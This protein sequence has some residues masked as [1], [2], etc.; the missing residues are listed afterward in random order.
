MG[1]FGGMGGAA[2]DGSMLP[3]YV[4]ALHYFYL[5]LKNLNV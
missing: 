4:H 2:G 1:W 5:F 3:G